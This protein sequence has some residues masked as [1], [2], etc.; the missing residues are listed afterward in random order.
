MQ[1]RKNYS[2]E[3]VKNRTIQNR[4]LT[5][6]Q[7]V[8]NA[9]RLNDQYDSILLNNRF[10]VFNSAEL[11]PEG[12]LTSTKSE[13]NADCLHVDDKCQF[14]KNKTRNLREKFDNTRPLTKVVSRVNKSTETEM[15]VVTK[16]LDEN[17]GGELL[18][19][20]KNANAGIVS[21]VQVKVINMIWI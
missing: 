18:S 8:T 20:S 2:S 21:T 1:P 10:N 5:K 15:N 3:A 4:H 19:S 17:A 12:A 7:K 6:L 16:S 14:E 9:K 13:S 11:F